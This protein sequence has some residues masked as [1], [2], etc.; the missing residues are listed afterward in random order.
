MG[1]DMYL[2][3]KTYVGANYEHNKVEGKISLKKQENPIKV[4]LKRVT[5]IEEQMGYWRKAN[6]IH[7]YFVANIQEGKDD[8]GDYDLSIEIV[9]DL[10]DRCKKVKESLSNSKTHFVK[11]K[12]RWNSEG[13]TFIDVEVFSNTDLAQELLPT[14]SGF[15]FGGT[16][17]NKYYL[18][19]ISNTINILE[20]ILLE[21][22][23]PEYLK[24]EHYYSSSW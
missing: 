18:E 20:E 9:F 22:D 24:E 17:Y 11:V 16:E 10:L 23:N 21:N 13:D 14:E 19:T 4:N 1:L 7:N 2:N 15:F 12:N 3:K 8:C 5:Y 6:Q